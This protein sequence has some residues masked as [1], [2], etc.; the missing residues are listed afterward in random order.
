MVGAKHGGSAS[1]QRERNK[2]NIFL[3]LLPLFAV[4][5]ERISSLKKKGKVDL[6]HSNLHVSQFMNEVF[7]YPAKD[8]AGRLGGD[9]RARWGG[10]DFLLSD[11]FMFC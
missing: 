7:H 2:K 11:I 8:E 9:D 5:E 1:R 4:G 6:T 3:S 10:T